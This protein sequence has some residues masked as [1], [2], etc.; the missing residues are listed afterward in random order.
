MVMHCSLSRSRLNLGCFSKVLPLIFINLSNVCFLTVK[1]NSMRFMPLTIFLSMY[2]GDNTIGDNKSPSILILS[3]EREK[4]LNSYS[5]VQKAHI[6]MLFVGIFRQGAFYL[7]HLDN[8]RIHYNI[9]AKMHVIALGEWLIIEASHL[10]PY[11]YLLI[12]QLT[13]E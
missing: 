2:S 6:L 13:Y 3:Y 4:L 1:H 5:S 12:I 10:P 9:L 8:E 11:I 7:H